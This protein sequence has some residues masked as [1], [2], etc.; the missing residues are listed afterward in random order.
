LPLPIPPLTL[1]LLGD[2]VLAVLAIILTI[3]AWRQTRRLRRR[4]DRFLDPRGGGNVADLVGSHHSDILALKERL[5]DTDKRLDQL[6]EVVHRTFRRLGVVRYSA[7][8]GTG[9]DLSFSVALLND[10]LD[11]L[12]LTGLYGREETRVYLKP[13]QGGTSRYPLSE[14][15]KEAI[16]LAVGGQG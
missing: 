1:A 11:G 6:S 3:V 15:E 12:V 16:R 10:D 9:A 5:Q 8:A 7:F 13:V 4:L 14:E 2:A